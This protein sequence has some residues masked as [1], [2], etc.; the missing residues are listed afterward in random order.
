M[1]NDLIGLATLFW[2]VAGLIALAGR[3]VVLGRGL[4][5]LGCL[6][7]MIAAI[8]ALPGASPPVALPVFRIADE[9]S[10][11]TLSPAALW[12]FGFGL[13]PAMLA[14]WLGSPGRGGRFWLFGLSMS[15]I[16]A[17]GVFGVTQGA[18]FLVAWEVMSLGGAA[19]I[20]GERLAE[21]AGS[22][23]LFMLGLLEVGAVALLAAVLVLGTASG[24]LGFAGIAGP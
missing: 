2:L 9:G 7:G 4:A 8:L 20:L 22:R 11:F 12:L 18:A 10:G 5:G 24:S 19:M 13:A 16:G 3:G 23:A 6:A 15:L 21:G 1:A 14:A 17:L